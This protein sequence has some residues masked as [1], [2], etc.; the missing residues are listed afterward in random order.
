MQQPS[1]TT[2]LNCRATGAR[3]LPVSLV[4]METQGLQ[5]LGC[6]GLSHSAVTMQTQV[7]GRWSS[8]GREGP[9]EV[10]AGTAE[11]PG[12]CETAEPRQSHTLTWWK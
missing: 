9:A 7:T 11:V 3:P 8:V 10:S 12:H 4:S 6:W 1:A 2:S 5:G